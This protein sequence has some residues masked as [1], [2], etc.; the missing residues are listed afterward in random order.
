VASGTKQRGVSNI[1][2]NNNNNNNNNKQ[3]KLYKMCGQFF[4][5]NVSGVRAKSNATDIQ[6]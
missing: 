4:V 1:N 6:M 3:E 5:C 2:N